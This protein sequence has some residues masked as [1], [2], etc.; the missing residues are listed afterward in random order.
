MSQHIV[1]IT[2]NLTLGGVQKSVVALANH[3]AQSYKVSVVLFESRPIAYALHPA[4]TIQTLPWFALDSSLLRGADRA[5]TLRAGRELFE[6]RVEALRTLALQAD[7]FVSF[8]DYHNLIALQA[9]PR[10]R[11]IVSSRVNL[12]LYRHRLIHLLDECFFREQIAIHYPKARAVVANSPGIVRD[13]TGLGVAV[14][15][16]PNGIGLAALEAK[17]RR[18]G[19]IA[20][21]G[22]TQVARLDLAQK[23]QLDLLLAYE[24]SGSEEPLC[25]IGGGKGWK[26]LRNRVRRSRRFKKIALMGFRSDPHVAIAQAKRVALPSYSEGF[27]NVLLEA[28]ALRTPVVAYRFDE[29]F[30]RLQ[31]F[32]HSVRWIGKGHI[33]A[34][35]QALRKRG[36]LPIRSELARFSIQNSL[37]QWDK[38]LK[39]EG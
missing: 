38:L 19:R 15:F 17:R 8:E 10:D 18:M 32:R 16:I 23:G 33:N 3:W 28:S 35:A 22:I 13:L 31:P 14:R 25:F 27:P 39:G 6:R 4:I 24:R 36:R 7:R 12:S 1:L 2:Q 30:V 29:D 11:L 9:L 5:Q 26:K 20:P 34:L 21:Q 37:W